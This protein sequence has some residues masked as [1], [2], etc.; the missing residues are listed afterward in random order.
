MY[1]HYFRLTRNP[2]VI[3]KAHISGQEKSS[4]IQVLA[5]LIKQRTNALQMSQRTEL[6]FITIMSLMNLFGNFPQQ[7]RSYEITLSGEIM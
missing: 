5:I 1:N 7:K 4:R 3:Y 6:L 2:I